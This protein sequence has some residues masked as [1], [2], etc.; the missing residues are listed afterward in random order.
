V[1]DLA[2]VIERIIGDLAAS[3][4]ASALVGGIAISVRTEPRF[5][6]DVDLAVDVASDTDAEL[7]IANLAARGWAVQAVLEQAATERL[8]AARLQAPGEDELGRVVDLLFASSGIEPELVAAADEL[9]ILPGLRVR[10]ARIGHLIVLKAL[11]ES[12]SRPQDRSDIAALVTR[13]DPE[14]IRLAHVAARLVEQRG[15]ARGRA[16]AERVERLLAGRSAGE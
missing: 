9:E 16:L 13:A 10:V 2:G 5:T 8:A 6:R 15:Y 14:D 1:I 7:L 4:V 11:A 3:N 12:E